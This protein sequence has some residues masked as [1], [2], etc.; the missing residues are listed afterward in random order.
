MERLA[1]KVAIVTGAG[2]GL[3]RTTAELFAAE[4]AAVVVA[5]IDGHTA[6]DAAGQ[7]RANG[8]RAVAVAIDVSSTTDV[9]RMVDA[10]AESYGRIDILVNNA[11]ITGPFT[12]VIDVS[13][14]E[15]D[16]VMAVNLKGPFLCTKYVLPLM[17]AQ[18]SGSIVNVSSA[19]GVIANEHQAAYNAS[20][21]GVIGLTRCTAQDCGK[22]GI[23]AN[24]VCPTGMNTPMSAS[25][26][27]ERDRTELSPTVAQTVFGRLAEPIEVARAILF[28][29][30][31]DAG[32]MTG[33]VVMVDGGLTAMQPSYRQLAAGMENF[34]SPR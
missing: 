29:A 34:L 8:G 12:D 6:E 4:G 1:G 33:A 32:F 21:H 17:R 9:R 23:R 3:G 5:D 27:L 15:W 30:S 13:E 18:A 26:D 16:T 28:L 20:K 14:E 25:M 19:S 2:R 10:A 31:D 7:I 24:A 11:A 22:F